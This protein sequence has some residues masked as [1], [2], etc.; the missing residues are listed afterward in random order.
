MKDL[1]LKAGIEGVTVESAAMHTDEIGNDIHRG[2][3][4]KLQEK[5]VA[6]APRQAW[7]LTAA[8]AREYDLIVG[9]DGYNMADLRR[10]VYPEDLPKLRKLMSFVGSER[11]VA[12]HFQ[13]MPPNRS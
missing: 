7:Q 12:K 11:D 3:R 2:T 13:D 5:G 9:M 1:L 8:K 10:L 6:F 4:A